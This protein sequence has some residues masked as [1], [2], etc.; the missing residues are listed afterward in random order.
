V[1]LKTGDHV[2]CS[3]AV[4]GAT[5]QLYATLLSKFGIETTFVSPSKLDEWQRALRPATKLLFLESPSNPLGEVAD[6]AALVIIMVEVSM[7]LFLMESLRITRLFP[8]IGALPDKVRVRMMFVTF[9]ILLM[10]ASVE[11]GLAYMREILMQDELATAAILRGGAET[12]YPEF[13]QKLVSA[14]PAR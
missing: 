2:V 14:T 4:F 6:I 8:V 11:A 9:A 12:T 5:V 7:G 3:N 10:L 13:Q 1:L